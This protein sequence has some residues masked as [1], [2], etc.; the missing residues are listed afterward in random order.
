MSLGPTLLN[1]HRTMKAARGIVSKITSC[2]FCL[3]ATAATTALAEPREQDFGNYT[4][5]ADV[6]HSSALSD[7]TLKLHG[8]SKTSQRQ[9]LDVVVLRAGKPPRKTVPALIVAHV[10]GPKGY[11]RQIDMHAAR[12]KGRVSWLGEI[13]ATVPRSGL[14]FVVTAFPEDDTAVSME[15]AA[16]PLQGPTR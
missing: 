5:R 16:G 11:V 6:V 12:A 4:I 9:L 15:F 14:R 10:R 2:V 1:R 8:L 3:L 13:P 7:E